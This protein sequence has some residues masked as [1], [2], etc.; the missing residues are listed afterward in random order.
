MREKNFVNRLLSGLLYFLIII[1]IIKSNTDSIIHIF[2]SILMLGC[3]F[4]CYIFFKKNKKL[5]LILMIYILISFYLLY[6]I[7]I[8]FDNIIILFIF[9]SC[10]S[11]DVGGYLI[12]KKFGKTKI[13]SFSPLKTLAGFVGSFVFIFLFLFFFKNEFE[14]HIQISYMFVPFIIFLSTTAG[15]LIISY[16]KRILDIKESGF[17]LSGHGG[18]LDRLDSLILTNYATYLII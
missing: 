6:C 12:G 3:I 2:L 8:N 4:E 7:Q 5:S 15:D 18:F 10:I 17:F 16:S 9:Y 13:I 11:S 1:L 14:S